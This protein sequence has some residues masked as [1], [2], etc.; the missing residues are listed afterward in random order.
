MT[1]NKRKPPAAH[2]KTH[3][4]YPLSARTRRKLLAD[5][6]RRAEAGDNS[7]AAALVM[8]SLRLE[9]AE[10]LAGQAKTES[11]AA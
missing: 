8:I 11:A 3:G 10:A 4:A 7:A 5:M 1:G 6:L 2:G 9:P